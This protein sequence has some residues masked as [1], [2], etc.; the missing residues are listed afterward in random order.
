MCA[1]ARTPGL[2]RRERT[3]AGAC[4]GEKGA[5]N[6]SAMNGNARG[7]ASSSASA[8]R[9]PAKPVIYKSTALAKTAPQLAASA[10]AADILRVSA[11]AQAH[12][13]AE[14]VR[15]SFKERRTKKM[16]EVVPESGA[17]G[18]EEETG[19]KA[20]AKKYERRL[21]MNRQSA[22]ASRV[23]REAYIKALEAQLVRLEENQ[24]IL[25][26]E[27]HAERTEN[28]QLKE[29][30]RAREVQTDEQDILTGQVPQDAAV[31][32]ALIH[33]QQQLFS[34]YQNVVAQ[35]TVPPTA[36]TRETAPAAERLAPVDISTFLVDP[37]ELIA[38]NT[39]STLQ[40]VPEMVE[41][42]V[43]LQQ[44]APQAPGE[45]GVTFLEDLLDLQADVPE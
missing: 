9:I 39:M 17:T 2:P 38:S 22:A 26:E 30:M 20:N 24:K 37:F 29:N 12:E 34:V 23:R 33:Q 28:A 18:K 41:G 1:A 15:E 13:Q 8:R 35:Q 16:D 43:D 19:E 45:D 14:R 44:S 4:G 5:A 11:I 31:G 7:G 27:L 6:T 40:N 10:T 3:T 36:A 32:D 25:E 21:K 42:N